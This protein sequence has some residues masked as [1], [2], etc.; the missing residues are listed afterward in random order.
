MKIKKI[1][2][3]SFR[4]LE[5]IE[6]ELNGDLNIFK[7][8][9]KLGKSTIIDSAMWVLCGETLINGVQ[10]QDNRNQNNLK[11]ELNVILEMD[12]GIIL[13]RKYKDIWKEDEYGDLKYART[14]NDFFVNGAKYKKGEYFEYIKDTLNLT[15]RLKV[16]KFKL[17]RCLMDYNYFC[18]EETQISRQFITKDLLGLETDEELL[19][20]EEFAL[21]RDDMRIQKYADGK[22]INK[23]QT[24]IKQINLEIDEKKSIIENAKKNIDEDKLENYQK[25]VDERTSL[26]ITDIRS[27]A[28]YSS[29]IERL[30]EIDI[31]I[32]E[33][34]KNQLKTKYELENRKLSLVNEGH[35]I[36]F[37][38]QDKQNNIETLKIA[39][40][41]NNNLIA[42][43]EKTISYFGNEEVKKIVCPNCNTIVNEKEIAI[44]KKNNKSEIE[45]IKKDIERLSNENQD[46][47]NQIENL[48]KDIESLQN[49]KENYGSEYHDCVKKLEE[50]EKQIE[51][52]EKVK[53][54][55]LEKEKVNS[56]LNTFINDYNTEK[57]EKICELN[58]Q[59]SI[60]DSM[61]ENLKKIETQKMIIDNLKGRKAL[62]ENC[63]YLVK[64]FKSLRNNI[65]KENISKAFPNVEIEIIEESDKTGCTEEVCYAKLKGVE[66]K[67]INDGHRYLVGIMI[68]ENIKRVLGL[69][70][71]PLIFDKFADI[72]GNT[73]KQIQS[74]TKSQ[75]ITTLVND[76]NKITLSNE[77]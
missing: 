16:D 62:L 19:N 4:G 55:L 5:N 1:I 22:C 7:G 24:E 2:I 15:K 63:I 18:N 30:N 34:Q 39:I 52:N 20:R 70:D 40:E 11:A 77:K 10:D 42:E 69:S 45:K 50:V 25:L 29:Y 33:E 66:Y 31:N 13:E 71:L 67:A 59:I 36:N 3:N 68:I 26:I 60:L 17:L 32:Q 46:K 38:I 47:L 44:I 54:L 61:N 57:N 53:E 14:Q 51:S 64:E 48:K 35:K 75:I 12:N 74:I 76:E 73:L 27:N 56:N 43:R 49:K 21:I 28:Q 6:F 37:A 58:E 9:N 41:K 65:I 8:A 23:Y 72:D